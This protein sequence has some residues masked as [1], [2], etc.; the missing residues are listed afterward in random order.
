MNIDDRLKE[1]IWKND[2]SFLSSYIKENLIDKR[3][4]DENNDTLFLYAISIAES[5]SFEFFLKNKANI[6]AE[7]DEGEGVLHSIVYSGELGRLKKFIE[8]VSI[9]HRAKDGA[10]P[11]L[12]ALS[13]GKNELAE[14]LI[15]N[16]ADVNIGDD[17][18]VH[19]L[20]LAAQMTD[21]NIVKSLIMKGADLR[22][23]TSFGN[24]P[25]SLAA[26]N[27]NDEIVKTLYK[28]MYV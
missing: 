21:V 19:P 9:N 20:H 7:N 3:F 1:A 4:K 13:L 27:G 2:I 28:A 18:E 6:F 26:N 11:L 5:N 25:I 12:L 17:K 14:F 22:S 23:K 10:T 24:L 16:G 15:E 8:E